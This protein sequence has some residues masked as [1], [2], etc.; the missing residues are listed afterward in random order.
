MVLFCMCDVQ[1]LEIQDVTTVLLKKFVK[2]EWIQVGLW[3]S[4]RGLASHFYQ[5][6]GE[7]VVQAPSATGYFFEI[8]YRSLSVSRSVEYRPIFEIFSL[9]F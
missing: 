6:Y 1:F 7:S 8:I 2:C 5:T 4:I 9:S 3:L